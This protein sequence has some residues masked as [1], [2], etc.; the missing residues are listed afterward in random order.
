MKP[1]INQS[2]VMQCD[3]AR[4]V[5][6]CSKVGFKEV[7]LNDSKLEEYFT[8]HSYREIRVLLR[9]SNVH[10]A[11]VNALAFF[12]LVP[13]EN[14]DFVLKKAEKMMILCQF[15]ECDSLVV[16]PSKNT[17]NL[18]LSEIKTKTIHRLERLADL[19]KSYG[20][21]VSFEPIGHHTYSIRKVLDGL[22]IVRGIRN[23]KIGLT[24]DTFNFYLGEN[25]LE[26]LE[27]IPGDRISFVHFHDV[28]DL[29]LDELSDENRLF[30]GE[31]VIDLKGF[32]KIFRDKDYHG[33]LSVELINP[34][35]EEEPPKELIEKT[36]KSLKKY[37]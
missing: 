31:G 33:P 23:H 21:R 30:P 17:H 11:T 32:C 19:G 15:V 9:Q 5:K 24:I 25:T 35:L 10:V 6:M 29:P 4:F 37:L 27:K 1:C 13:E 16:C 3:T 18:S 28:A 7:E 2:T 36:W 22:D 26:D 20:I 12:S 34:K 8:D 14:F